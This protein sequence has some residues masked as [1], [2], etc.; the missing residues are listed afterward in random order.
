MK[1]ENGEPVF[2]STDFFDDADPVIHVDGGLS[3]LDAA[4]VFAYE[5]AHVAVGEEHQHDA[6]WEKVFDEINEEYLRI[7]K[8][9]C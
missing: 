9:P 2:G 3:V 6:V 8:S 7:T 4:E 5:L 1:D